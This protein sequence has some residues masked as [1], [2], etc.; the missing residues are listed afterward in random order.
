MWMTAPFPLKKKTLRI[1][2]QLTCC[3]SPRK[4]IITPCA[5]VFFSRISQSQHIRLNDIYTTMNT[6]EV[7]ELNHKVV[8]QVVEASDSGIPYVATVDWQ[9]WIVLNSWFYVGRYL[10]AWL[11]FYDF[12]RLFH[13]ET[14]LKLICRRFHKYRNKNTASTSTF[15]FSAS[16]PSLKVLQRC[17]DILQLNCM[18]VIKTK[19]TT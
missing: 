13:T 5:R 2:C 18:K 16:H 15:C 11:I 8:F 19:K 9:L 14:R 4:N 17:T 6:L 1:W 3:L 12:G 7:R 10:M